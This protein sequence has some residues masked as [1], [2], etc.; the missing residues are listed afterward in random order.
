VACPAL[1]YFSTSHKLH[2]L[3]KEE[4]E[5]EEKAAEQKMCVFISLTTFI[6]FISHSKKNLSRYDQKCV[7]VFM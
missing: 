6:R 2:D 3:K 7:S 5:E 4:E 1:Q